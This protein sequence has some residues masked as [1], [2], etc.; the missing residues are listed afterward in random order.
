MGSAGGVGRFEEEGWGVGVKINGAY[1]F[2]FFSCGRHTD[3]QALSVFKESLYSS[4]SGR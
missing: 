2:G 3:G 4:V 1:G